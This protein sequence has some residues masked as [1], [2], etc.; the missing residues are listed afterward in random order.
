LI[1]EALAQLSGIAGSSDGGKMAQV[2]VRF[3]QSVVP[4]AEILLSSKLTRT[5]GALQL[6]DVSASVGGNIVARGTLT[7]HRGK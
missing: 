1:A 6:F 5:I 7:L 2:D 4:P 3:D